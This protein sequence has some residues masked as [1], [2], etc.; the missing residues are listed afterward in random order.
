MVNTLSK[1]NPMDAVWLPRLQN[2]G[3]GGLVIVV[4][5]KSCG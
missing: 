3:A 1:M 4:C 2:V 5:G